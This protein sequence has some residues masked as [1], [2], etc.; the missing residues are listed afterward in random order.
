VP[1]SELIS[2]NAI[3]ISGLDTSAAIDVTGGYYSIDDGPFTNAAGT[4]ANGQQLQLQVFNT[5]EPTTSREV[6]VI[7]GGEIITFTVTTETPDTRPDNFDFLDSNNAP[8]NTFIT[9]NTLTI[10]GINTDTP[11]SIV[12]G[13]YAIDGGAFTALPGTVNG[14]QSIQLR[15]T[16]AGLPEAATTAVV[17]IGGVEDSFRVT[18]EVAD[19]SILRP[20]SVSVAV[21]IRLMVAASPAKIVLSPQ[22]KHCRFARSAPIPPVAPP[23]RP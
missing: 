9:S 22:D 23:T 10:P 16:S 18:T 2:S 8:L 13:E 14:T 5:A 3:T 17:T 4:I 19:V 15:V 12:D 1:F 21:N 11:I 6:Q 7:V 20:L